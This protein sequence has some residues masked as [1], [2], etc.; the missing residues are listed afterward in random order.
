MLI[1]DMMWSILSL[2]L[3]LAFAG[4]KFKEVRQEEGRAVWGHGDTDM[5]PM[6]GGA[7]RWMEQT[8][9]KAL[10]EGKVT[11]IYWLNAR[12]WGGDREVRN[13]IHQE[14]ELERRDFYEFT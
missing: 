12:N 7:V 1:K 9:L 13:A 6:A 11:K 3:P 14:S 10:Q 8:G 4:G 5:V 2:Q